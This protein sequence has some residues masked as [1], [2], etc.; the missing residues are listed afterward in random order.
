LFAKRILAKTAK[1]TFLYFEQEELTS[2]DA[3]LQAGWE[4][5]VEVFDQGG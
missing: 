3:I 2:P 4:R 5:L 1:E